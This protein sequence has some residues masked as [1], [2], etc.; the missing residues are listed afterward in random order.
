M[1][2]NILVVPGSL[3]SGSHNRRLAAEAA[4]QLSLTEAV[5]TLLDLKDYPLPVYDG[6]D[7]A[8]TGS[9]KRRAPRPADR[10]AGRA[11][12]GE[13]GVQSS[14]PAVL[15][16]AV[17]WASR[18]RKVQ[19]RPVQPFKGLIVGL[20][21]ASTGR[22]GG[23]RSLEALRIVFRALGAEVLTLQCSVPDAA[24]GFDRAGGWPATCRAGAGEPR[25]AAG[26]HR[27]QP[28]PARHLRAAP[29]RARG[30][31]ARPCPWNSGRRG[32]I[33]GERRAGRRPPV[34]C[35]GSLPR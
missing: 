15:K 2:A 35:K 10:G 8:E 9:Q 19:G 11:P 17:D 31:G 1:S 34:L 29:P 26:R 32:P 6:D 14:M 30:L 7:E 21:S 20:A 33:C 4:R 18:V 22:Y 13:P 25:R 5:V 12:G 28:R 24:N 3:R 16:N 23:M 27:P